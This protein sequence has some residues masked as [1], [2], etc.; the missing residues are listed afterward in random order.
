MKHTFLRFRLNLRFKAL[1][2][3]N[4]VL[5]SSETRATDT[6]IWR[7]SANGQSIA[8]RVLR[9]SERQVMKH[10]LAA[11]DCARTHGIPVPGVIRSGLIDQRYP[12]MAIEWISGETVGDALLRN[13][14]VANRLGLASGR[15]LS[16]IHEVSCPDFDGHCSWIERGTRNDPELRACLMRIASPTPSLLHLD[17]HPFNLIANGGRL[18]GVLDWTNAVSGDPRADIARTI[19]IMQVVAPAFFAPHGAFRMSMGLFVRGFITGYAARS[20]KLTGMAPFYAWAGNMLRHDLGQKINHLPVSKPAR[21]VR[22]IERW[23][24][25][26]RQN[27]LSDQTVDA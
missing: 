13:R 25:Y 1:N 17:Y 12:A 8:I 18:N 21:F 3:N 4:A 9:S 24:G 11:M 22:N 16:R 26:W 23:A 20:G 19:S 15:L 27:A 5:Q 2:L 7:V 10:E 6:R 14:H